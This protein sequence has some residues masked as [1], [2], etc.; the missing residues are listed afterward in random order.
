[1]NTYIVFVI[2]GSISIVLIAVYIIYKK[3]K[4]AKLPRTGTFDNLIPAEK[5]EADSSGIKSPTKRRFSKLRHESYSI[6]NIQE[7]NE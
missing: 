2:I 6:E 1:M 3:K 4:T 5:E 7:I